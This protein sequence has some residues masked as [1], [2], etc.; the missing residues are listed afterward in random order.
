M[1]NSYDSVLDVWKVDLISQRAKKMGFHGQD[2]LDAQ[3]QIVMHLLEHPIDLEQLRTASETTM[4]TIIV[5]KQLAMLHRKETRYQRRLQNVRNNRPDEAPSPANQCDRSLDVEE[6]VARLTEIEQSIC[7]ELA[8]GCSINETATRLGLAWHTIRRHIN[9]IRK[10]FEQVGLQL[11]SPASAVNVNVASGESSK[12]L[13]AAEAAAT[14]HKSVR[15]WRAWDA[16]G[17]V[18]RPVRIGRSVFWRADEL[19]AWI[20]ARCPARSE[21]DR[22][23]A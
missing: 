6:A 2:L 8:S 23:S 14:C 19:H 17:L 11:E 10:H 15:T 18:P 21:W 3:Q 13:T 9:R 22:L 20:A 5:D 1:Q 7:R 4:L 16:A 12:L